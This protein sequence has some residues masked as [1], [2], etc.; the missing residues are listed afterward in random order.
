MDGSLVDHDWKRN[1]FP[2]SIS[3]AFNPLSL[4]PNKK[5][6]TYKMASLFDYIKDASEIDEVCRTCLKKDEALNSLFYLSVKDVPL[7][8]LVTEVTGLKASLIN[9]LI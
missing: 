3:S 1:A 2:S 9:L 4:N 8:A 6:K 5:K 7:D